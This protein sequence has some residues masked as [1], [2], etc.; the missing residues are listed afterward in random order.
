MNSITRLVN[1]YDHVTVL[2][3]NTTDTCVSDTQ[4]EVLDFVTIHVSNCDA[5][6]TA[7]ICLLS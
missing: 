6:E 2:V 5:I 4:L 3:D 7:L 1:S